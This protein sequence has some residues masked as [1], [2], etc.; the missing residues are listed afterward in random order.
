MVEPA[1]PWPSNCGLL[2]FEK[3]LVKSPIVE[4]E[5]PSTPTHVGAFGGSTSK[6]IFKTP[7]QAETLEAL[8]PST[9]AFGASIRALI[10]IGIPIPAIDLVSKSGN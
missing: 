10:P 7:D 3:K 6:R 5:R 9:E 8:A 4:I 1:S 2:V